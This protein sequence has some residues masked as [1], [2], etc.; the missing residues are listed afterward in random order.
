MNYTGPDFSRF[1]LA[2]LGVPRSAR[3]LP[4]SPVVRPVGQG[5][6]ATGYRAIQNGFDTLCTTA[7]KLIEDLSNT[8]QKGRLQDGLPNAI[9]SSTLPPTHE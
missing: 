6:V 5:A 7:A 3:R 9:F 2:R 1:L 8:S 4:V